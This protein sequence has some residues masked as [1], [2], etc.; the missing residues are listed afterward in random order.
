MTMIKVLA[1]FAPHFC[2][3]LWER[4]GGGYSVFNQKYPEYDEKAL[5]LDEIEYP[6][7]INGKVRER[8]TAP[9]D[10]SREELEEYVRGQF[11][12][13]FEGKQIIKF[14]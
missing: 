1:P 12:G 10:I 5:V 13:L 8:F 4:F 3:E 6:L 7:Q 11:A 9:K 14:M 2:E